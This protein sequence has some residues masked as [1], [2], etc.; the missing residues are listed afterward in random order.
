MCITAYACLSFCWP[1]STC[2]VESMTLI[3][4]YY[5]YVD[6]IKVSNIGILNINSR[7]I[8]FHW[9]WPYDN[10]TCSVSH[11]E[12]TAINCGRCP[13][14]TNRLDTQVTCTDIS[15]DGRLCTFCVQAIGTFNESKT[16]SI[17]ALLKG[18]ILMSQKL[19]CN[20]ISYALSSRYAQ[21]QCYTLSSS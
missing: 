6:S 19:I 14:E 10:M 17:I 11:Y 9:T 5:M 16:V 15:T 13:N 8:T 4:F 1:S 20:E 12:L 7:E 21:S 2:A 18:K 3:K